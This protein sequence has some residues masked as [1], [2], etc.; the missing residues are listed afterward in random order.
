MCQDFVDFGIR[1]R[2]SL[3]VKMPK[4]DDKYF[5]HFL[6]GVIEGDGSIIYHKNRLIVTI[7]SGSLEFLQAINNIVGINSSIFK[8]NAIYR[9]AYT[10]KY[11]KTLCELIYKDSE[12]LRLKRKYD[13][14]A[15]TL[16]GE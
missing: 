14:Y 1:Q 5:Y 13:K 15:Q 8:T 6:R 16:L 7:N 2:K 9:I 10:G 4:I 12:G 11:A 3:T